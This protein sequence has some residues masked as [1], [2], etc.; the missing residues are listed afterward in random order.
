MI[1]VLIKYKKNEIK[2]FEIKGHANAPR[3]KNNHDLICA[4]VSAVAYGILNSLNDDYIK[5]K[6]E[7]GYILIKVNKHTSENNL[8]LE[9]LKT[10]L[11][12][13]EEDN[14]KYISIKEEE[15]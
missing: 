7:D 6:I 2:E 12:T 14:S 1:K 11:K 4:S 8:I 9:V 10:S 3:T 15:V 5:V 13:I